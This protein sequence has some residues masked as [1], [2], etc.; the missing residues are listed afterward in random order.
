VLLRIFSWPKKLKPVRSE[1][2]AEESRQKAIIGPKSKIH[3]AAEASKPIPNGA[4][5][6]CLPAIAAPEFC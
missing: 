5:K 4:V 6:L 3:E 2:G 1:E